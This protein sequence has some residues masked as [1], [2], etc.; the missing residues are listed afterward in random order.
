MTCLIYLF[1]WFSLCKRQLD[2]MHAKCFGRRRGSLLQQC[3]SRSSF[4]C[5][6]LRASSPPLPALPTGSRQTSSFEARSSSLVLSFLHLRLVYGRCVALLRY[7][8]GEHVCPFVERGVAVARL[9]DSQLHACAC[10]TS[11][12]DW[13]RG[14]AATLV[15]ATTIHAPLF[16]LFT[17]ENLYSSLTNQTNKLPS[18]SIYLAILL[19]SPGKQPQQVS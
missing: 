15:G 11:A 18:R 14:F 12:G 1:K 10:A 5:F 16:P 17:G 2:Y 6:H 9:H 19:S 3:K 8:T 4:T 13:T 7:F